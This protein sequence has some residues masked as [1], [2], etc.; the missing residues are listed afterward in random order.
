MTPL[1]TLILHLIAFTIV[2]LLPLC[3]SVA[4]L[5]TRAGRVCR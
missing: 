4:G 2:I 3:I 5:V 1:S